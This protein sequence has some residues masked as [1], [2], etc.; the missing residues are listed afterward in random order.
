M[1]GGKEE[2]NSKKWN[3][4]TPT[5]K[6]ENTLPVRELRISGRLLPYVLGERESG[7]FDTNHRDSSSK[8]SGTN[9]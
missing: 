6:K 3:M 7:R 5:L 4:L 8:S 1:I 9:F 2:W